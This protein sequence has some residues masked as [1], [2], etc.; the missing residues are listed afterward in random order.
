MT[1]A[2]RRYPWFADFVELAL[3][4]D[5]W[6]WAELM[7]AASPAAEGQ[8]AEEELAARTYNSGSA[9]RLTNY[10]TE[11]G[12]EGDTLFVFA[13][14]EH[15]GAL[16]AEEHMPEA[17]RARGE[18]V[19]YLVRS[20]SGDPV[21]EG[22]MDALTMERVFDRG[23]LR[24]HCLANMHR[25]ARD[26]YAPLT[27]AFGDTIEPS[28]SAD[29]ARFVSH[30]DA[31]HRQVVGASLLSVPDVDPDG[32]A[33]DPAV[34]DALEVALGDWAET[35]DEV[36]QAEAAKVPRG[37]G[38]LGE[39]EFWRERNTSL[40]ALYEQI[41]LPTVQRMLASLEAAEASM[42]PTFRYHFS[43]LTKLY[44]EAKDNVKFLTT[45]ERHFK[46]IGKGSFASI[47]DTIP[48]MMNALRMVWIIS[49]HYSTD[50]RMVPLMERIA[51]EIADK[52]AREVNVG[53]ILG[54]AP[55]EALATIGDAKAVLQGWDAAYRAVRA[56]IEDS[57]SDHRWEFDRR[58]LFERTNHMLR[59]CGD[60]AHVAT[61][62]HQFNNFLGGSLLAEVTGE[63]DAVNALRHNVGELRAPLQQL[64]YDIFDPL[65]K[66]RWESRMATF[67]EGTT[68]L[69]LATTRFLNLSFQQLR[70]AEAAFDLL[71]NFRHIDTRASIQEDMSDKYNDIYAQYLAE[72]AALAAK[73]D[74]GRAAPPL[75]KNFPP[76]AGAIAWARS[77][78]ARA[79]ATVLK[80]KLRRDM[81]EAPVGQQLREK[82]LAF[83]RAVDAYVSDHFEAWRAEVTPVAT[84]AMGT[85]LFGPDLVLLVEAA[86][87]RGGHGH[88]H[89]GAKA[90]KK[91]QKK[92]GGQ[93]GSNL[94]KAPPRPVFV[95]PEPPYSVNFSDGLR[96]A[97]REAKFLDRLGFALPE[98][99]LNVALQEARFHSLTERLALVLAEYHRLLASMTTVEARVLSVQLAE[100]RDVV[101]TGFAP[102]CWK[103]QRIDDFIVGARQAIASVDS[104][105]QTLA[106]SSAS[107]ADIVD[108]IGGTSLIEAAD[109]EVLYTCEALPEALDLCESI[110]KRKAQRLD[111]LVPQYQSIGALLVKLEEE[112]ANSSTGA[113]EVMLGFYA[114]WEKRL[115]NAISTMVMRSLA[116]WHALLG[117]EVAGRRVQ[118][119]GALIGVKCTMVGKDIMTTP[120]SADV[121]KVLK[122]V[123]DNLVSAAG[124]FL[125]WKHGTCVETLP[126]LFP[127]MEEDDDPV[128]WSYYD[129]VENNPA[130]VALLLGVNLSI[131]R[132]LDQMAKYVGS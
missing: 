40:A 100:L 17:A 36:V 10:F 87:D 131:K 21:P 35:V 99:A 98:M 116:T 84:A 128:T 5:A 59:I 11:A 83:A 27:S 130:V 8:T 30:V 45:L 89:T 117:G 109:L 2:E 25:L 58:R 123:T 50:E 63:E 23:V 125:R 97:I 68:D 47:A 114:H 80:L 102:L 66:P 1:D 49:R 62:L 85:P 113:C 69:E 65:M 39:I 44:V 54:A 88:G 105:R 107:I 115:Y 93:G 33:T 52:V 126:Q 14:V 29:L 31:A 74:A 16:T 67:D 32:A 76:V 4:A 43:E 132:S 38:P 22:A 64:S 41:N 19:A 96:D 12:A 70:S 119:R 71:Q 56:K 95:M 55:E 77:L 42:L 108:A 120:R 28:Y 103:S 92:K 91:Q 51:E 73:F 82:Y 124:S 94:A 112:V 34:Y 9:L 72:L 86:E 129:D 121:F 110:E 75:F 101:R 57:G 90:G 13:D 122:R 60:L 18:L 104:L 46:N 118:T 48:P 20:V 15:G 111:A 79:K 24:G 61:V 26:V 53:V 78:Y 127:G 106:K 6:A 3:G 7:G 37:R 81:W